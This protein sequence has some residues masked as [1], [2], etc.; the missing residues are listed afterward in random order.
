MYY[1]NVVF[2]L[3][4]YVIT[5]LRV[6]LWWFILLQ[7]NLN[8][9]TVCYVFLCCIVN[10][11]IWLIICELLLND[12]LFHINMCQF[13]YLML[14][15]IVLWY[16]VFYFIDIYCSMKFSIFPCSHH[17]SL[18][19]TLLHCQII[20]LSYFVLRCN[21]LCRKNISYSTIL[22]FSIFTII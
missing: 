3:K 7:Y 21:N 6:L 5:I 20:H 4:L 11:T 8:F 22:N 9:L 19:E 16:I 14:L 2:N 15:Y 10:V 13:Y 17:F 18:L 12:M 1:Y